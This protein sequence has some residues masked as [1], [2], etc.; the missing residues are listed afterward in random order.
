MQCYKPFASRA[1][2]ETVQSYTI[3]MMTRRVKVI[4]RGSLSTVVLLKLSL[5]ETKFAFNM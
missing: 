2:D 4:L 3:D 5:K 1:E